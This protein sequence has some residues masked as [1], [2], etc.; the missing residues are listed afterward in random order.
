MPESTD[1]ALTIEAMRRIRGIKDEDINFDDIPEMT[2]DFFEKAERKRLMPKADLSALERRMGID[3]AAIRRVA[4]K[5]LTYMLAY[6][7]AGNHGMKW[8]EFMAIIG[9]ITYKPGWYFRTGIEDE[10]MWVQVGVTESIQFVV[11]EDRSNVDGPLV[12]RVEAKHRA[13]AGP[14]R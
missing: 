3:G 8:L 9:Q 10:R 13:A 5:N 2:D 1:S 14:R 11:L 12:A 7:S 4:P 6:G